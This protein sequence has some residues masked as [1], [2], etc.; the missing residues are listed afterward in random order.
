MR[1][2]LRPV[3]VL[4]LDGRWQWI[5]S[6]I[7]FQK[8]MSNHVEHE[9]SR[10]S[11][12]YIFRKILAGNPSHRSSKRPFFG[13]SWTSREVVCLF[14]IF[15]DDLAVVLSH[16]VKCLASHSSRA[17]NAG[18]TVRAKPNMLQRTHQCL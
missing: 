16:I 9:V 12:D 1:T 18:P 5:C 17:G 10:K 14:R 3:R 13:W 4:Q 2:F 7:I 6:R 11:K 8:C 15:W